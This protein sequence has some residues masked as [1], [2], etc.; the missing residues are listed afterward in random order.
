M[1]TMITMIFYHFLNSFFFFF[2]S[3]FLEIGQ[4]A[5]YNVYGNE[6]V[7]AA[8]IVAGIGLIHG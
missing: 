2:S 6:E 1:I 4:I 3:P 7:P 5:A 8:G